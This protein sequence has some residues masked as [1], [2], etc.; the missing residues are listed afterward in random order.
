MHT[1]VIKLRRVTWYTSVCHIFLA[2]KGKGGTKHEKGT[3]HKN[4]GKPVNRDGIFGACSI[5]RIDKFYMCLFPVPA[6]ITGRCGK[7]AS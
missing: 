7:T 2:K 4:D 3:D 5:I 1:Q 6:G